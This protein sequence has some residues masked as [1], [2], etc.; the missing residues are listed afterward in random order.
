MEFE[1]ILMMVAVWWS[2]GLS[3]WNGGGV[4]EIG[5]MPLA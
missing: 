2:M 4:V 3:L 5:I 1:E